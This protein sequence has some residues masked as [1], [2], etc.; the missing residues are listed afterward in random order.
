MH[1]LSLAQPL[2]WSADAPG[3]LAGT[4]VCGWV[5]CCARPEDGGDGVRVQRRT[6]MHKGGSPQLKSGVCEEAGRR[7]S[8][9]AVCAESTCTCV[10]NVHRIMHEAVAIKW[11]SLQAFDTVKTPAHD[12]A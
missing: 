8:N 10:D 6:H 12:V 7:S 9:A 4:G 2:I 1:K 5:R 11:Q 3:W